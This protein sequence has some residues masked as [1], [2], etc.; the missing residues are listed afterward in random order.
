M[1]TSY[2]SKSVPCFHWVQKSMTG[3]DMQTREF[4]D[5]FYTFV[6]IYSVFTSNK[7]TISHHSVNNEMEILLEHIVLFDTAVAPCLI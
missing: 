2:I 1:G 3:Y 4:A 7:I 5:I 6:E